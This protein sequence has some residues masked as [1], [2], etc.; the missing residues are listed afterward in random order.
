MSARAAKVSTSTTIAR[1]DCVVRAARG[2][3]TR[4]GIAFS[5]VLWI[6][7]IPVAEFRNDGRG[8]CH[9]WRVRDAGLFA[10]FEALAKTEYP[11]DRF[12]QADTFVG[13]LWDI[14]FLGH[15]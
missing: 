2:H 1:A 13:D 3:E 15:G 6:R 5:G 7:D 9:I 11:H 4:D 10:E 8:G 14:A 12:E